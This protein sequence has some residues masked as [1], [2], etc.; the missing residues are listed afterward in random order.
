MAT[1]ENS[2]SVLID[3][4]QRSSCRENIRSMDCESG[5]ETMYLDG[6]FR[7]GAVVCNFSFNVCFAMLS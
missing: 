6:C 4:L 7:P 1:E 2:T 5:A 3:Y